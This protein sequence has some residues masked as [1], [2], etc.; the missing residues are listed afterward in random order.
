MGIET[1]RYTDLGLEDPV[2]IV[3]FPS[4]GLVSS[5]AA[6]FYVSKLKMTPIAGLTGPEM[7]PYCL[8][9]DNVAY[10][11]IRMYGLKGSARKRDVVMCTSEFAPKPDDCHEI[12]STVLSELRDLGCRTVICLEGIPRTSESEAAVICGSGSS[13]GK[14]VESSGLQKMDNGMIKG[15]S[16][17]MMYL[18]RSHGMDVITVMC[19]ANPGMPDPGAAT[20]F[21]EPLS[22][23]VRGLKVDPKPL[24]EEAEEVR[25][26][27][28]AEQSP[29][30]N[31]PAQNAIYG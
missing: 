22:K 19:P 11:P 26:R 1:L 30:E 24:L 8:I 7:P 6:N 9:T 13:C 16:G 29:A 14:V 4:V 21:I 17:I 5:I 31:D 18:G 3:G 20:G 27:L 15:I 25:R 10:P 2:G 12:A 23:M 28:E